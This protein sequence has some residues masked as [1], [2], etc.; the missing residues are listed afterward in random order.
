MLKIVFR[1]FKAG[2]FKIAC[3]IYIFTLIVDLNSLTGPE[4]SDDNQECKYSV[5]KNL[6]LR[7]SGLIV[8]NEFVSMVNTLKVTQRGFS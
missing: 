2:F 4:T 3:S 7:A 5:W 6:E 8:E 1:D